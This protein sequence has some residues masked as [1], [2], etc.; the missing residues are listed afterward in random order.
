MQMKIQIKKIEIENGFNITMECPDGRCERIEFKHGKPYHE[1]AHFVAELHFNLA[2]GYYGKILRGT[3]LR[4]MVNDTIQSDQTDGTDML[5]AE[6]AAHFFQNA[7]INDLNLG[8]AKEYHASVKYEE[9]KTIENNLPDISEANFAFL[10]AELLA[11]WKQW[12]ELQNGESL[13]LI[14]QIH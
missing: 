9:L 4:R 12:D 3:H 11:L 6:E 10:K 14:F 13:N 1:L 2:G 5:V 7:V 8:Q